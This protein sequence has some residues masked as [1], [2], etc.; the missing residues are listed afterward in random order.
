MINN[1]E[2]V[3]SVLAL[4]VRDIE[5][6]TLQELADFFGREAGGMS[7]AAARLECRMQTSEALRKEI[8][9]TKNIMI[10]H[11]EGSC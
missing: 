9:N 10:N 3:R 4:L 7:K 2:T 5:G 1:N 11:M 8:E 6:V